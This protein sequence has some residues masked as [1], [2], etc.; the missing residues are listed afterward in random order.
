MVD[1]PDVPGDDYRPAAGDRQHT[2]TQ[3]QHHSA[4]CAPLPCADI[5]VAEEPPTLTGGDGTNLVAER[6]RRAVLSRI[7]IAQDD[8]DVVLY[9]GIEAL[10]VRRRI[11]CVLG[12]LRVDLRIELVPHEEVRRRRCE[13]DDHSDDAGRYERQTIAKGHGSRST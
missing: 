3:V 9:V 4:T 2:L 10:E 12:E 1:I 5:G 11:V 13:H 7:A 6:Q 8:G